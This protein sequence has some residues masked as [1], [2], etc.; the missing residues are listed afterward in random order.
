MTGSLLL[1]AAAALTAGEARVG[2]KAVGLARLGAAGAEVPW[3]SVLPIEAFVAHLERAELLELAEK[4]VA[5]DDSGAVEQ[6][7]QAI[8]DAPVDPDLAA[9]VAG[10]LAARGPFAVRSSAV[11]EDGA[12]RSFAG[13]HDS[14]LFVADADAVLD[15]VKRCWASVFNTRALAYRRDGGAH[16]ELPAIAV[17]VQQMVEGEVSGVL[18][19]ENPTGGEGELLI[20]ACWGLGEGIVHGVC[21]TDDLVLA[22]DGRELSVTVTDKDVRV[23][24]DPSGGTRTEP[25]PDGARTIRCLDSDAARG[26]ASQALAVVESLGAPQDIEWT[27]RDG[28]PVLLQTRP[29]T[30]R[31]KNDSVLGAWRTVWDNSNIQ[32]S[33]NGV[34]T[35]LTFSWAVAAYEVVF[36]E[37]LRLVRVD[38]RVIARHRPVLRN[39]IGLVDGRV[40]YNINNWYRLL[41]LG[42]WF[43]RNKDDVEKMMG[44]EHPVDFVEGIHLS[45]LE[46]I[47]RIPG[48]LPVAAGLAARLSRRESLV[49]RFQREVGAEIATIGREVA[50]ADDLSELVVLA[51]RVLELFGQW[52]V[53]NLN[54]L[55]LSNQAGRARRLLAP[56]VGTDEAAE[57]V[58]GLLAAQTSLASLEPTL[59]LMRLAAEIRRSPDLVAVLEAGTPEEAVAALAAADPAIAAEL[60]SYVE[61]FG[62]RCMGEQKLETVSLRQDRSFL[63]KILRNYVADESIDADLLERTQRDNQHAV[64]RRAFDTLPPRRR[65]RLENVLRGA[66]DAVS[67]RESMRLTRTRLVGLTRTIYLEAG[68]RLHAGGLLDEPRQVFYLTKD[69]IG[70]LVE[71]RAVTTDLAA[72]ARLRAAEYHDRHRQALPANQFETL[73]PPQ[74]GRR[75]VPHPDPV[76]AQG[77]ILRGTGCWPGVVEAELRIVHDPRDDLDVSG[78][79]L[80]ANRT[81]PGWAPLFPSVRGLLIERGSTLS[82][83][84]VIA[85]ELGIPTV[86]GVPGL[87]TTV[88][89]GECVRLDG[90]SGIVERLDE[91][92][93]GETTRGETTSEGVPWNAQ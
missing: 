22:H 10:A 54:D 43:D 53:P 79:I 34:T 19:T 82:H 91:P 59:R 28:R 83:S 46:K 71:G 40:Y 50:T 45:R 36:R 31:A 7:R 33:F 92:E 16:D 72:L 47:R 20:S 4:A 75:V 3:W 77:R 48:L 17:V 11:G 57:I 78:R 52:A 42:P 39:M 64:E 2:G 62:D 1:D 90:G 18:F 21:N 87:L 44:L 67:A 80:V 69:E 73:G 70:D 76:A 13:M 32:E 14:Y 89:D 12:E 51:D 5:V 56:T 60:D 24:R 15:A 61:Q 38:E 93:S 23:V 35:P 63:A 27:I 9:A 29:I 58:A 84:A 49:R 65:R 88:R 66:R 30:A 8:I 86:V 25:V 74:H 81:D 41:L 37:T 6:L 68:A 26:L 55:Y 85:R